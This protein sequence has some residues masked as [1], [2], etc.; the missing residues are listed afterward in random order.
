MND[1]DFELTV[2]DMT[3]TEATVFARYRGADDSA[4]RITG[5]L[6]G[7]YC[8]GVRTLMA[9]FAFRDLGPARPGVAEA[10]VTD[11]CM[12]SAEQPHLYQVELEALRG[13]DVLAVYHGTLGLKKSK[14]SD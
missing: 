12:W 9:E 11:L 4:V 10:A 2:G 6:R 14:K 3:G 1:D 8:E 13:D 5:I 7:P